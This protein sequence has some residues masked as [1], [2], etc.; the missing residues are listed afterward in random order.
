MLCCCCIDKVE[1]K[2][3]EGTGMERFAT[4][5]TPSRGIPTG[6]DAKASAI[7]WRRRRPNHEKNPPLFFF[8]VPSEATAWAPGPDV[9]TEV[10]LLFRL[11]AAPEALPSK[12]EEAPA[13]A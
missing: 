10:A 6:E 7:A 11:A 13:A 2:I 9:D 5:R 12:D 1:G 4:A 8:S 3:G